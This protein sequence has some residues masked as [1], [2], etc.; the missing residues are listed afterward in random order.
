MKKGVLLVFAAF[1]FFGT[2]PLFAGGG[3][4]KQQPAAK[5]KSGTITLW[6]TMT[7][8]ER[9]KAFDDLARVYEKENPGVTVKVEV[10]PWDGT[11]DKVV[12]S[13]M[14]K[15]PPEITLHGSGWP[16][17]L[18]GTGGILEMDELINEIGGTGKFLQMA[19]DLGKYETSYYSVPLY[20]TPYITM[21]RK[22]YLEKAGITKL[23]T[24]WEEFY[25]MC[26]AV[27]DP[28][29][30]IYGFGAPMTDIHSW[31]T[32]WVFL[33]SNNVNLVNADSGGNW[34]VDVS[35]ED[36]AAIIEVYD[37]LYRLI[38][39]CSPA[40]LI[41]YNQT[42]VRELVAKGTIMSRIDTPE[43]YYDVRALKDDATLKDIAYFSF[44]GRKR[45]GS[46]TGWVGMGIQKDSN[47]DLAKDYIKWLYT[48]DRM[49]DFYASYP[50]AMFPVLNETYKSSGYRAKLPDEIKPMLPDLALEILSHA[51]GLMMTNGP[52]PF[53][54]E[55]E[56]RKIFANP[57]INMFNKGITAAQA[58]DELIAETQALL[59]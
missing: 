21:Y 11:M 10:M 38:K 56:S 32:I 16:Q 59:N 52:F 14:A 19:L 20:V 58:A 24:T 35:P 47:V 50:Y 31:K 39:D 17:T 54:G 12:A 33:Q 1:M 43:I 3:G 2:L 55:V 48:G 42:N 13:I 44:P 57:L 36:R 25:T 6:S 8:T 29:K 26:K 40:G 41:G 49:V 30:N 18:A 37:Y 46:G 51:S 7:Q 9:A 23:P 45:I 15:N 28:G 27:T 34:R 4:E 5:G 53:A 22:S